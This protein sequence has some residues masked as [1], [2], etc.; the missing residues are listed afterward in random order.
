MIIVPLADIH[1]NLGH[2]DAVAK[3]LSAADT[4][5]LVGDLTDFGRET[6]VSRVVKTVRRHNGRILAV[7]GNCDYPEADVYLVHRRDQPAPPL[8][9][10]PLT[11]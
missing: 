3:D 11:H 1:D 2:L 5:L 8:P 7:P 6:E 9:C 4:V 10:T